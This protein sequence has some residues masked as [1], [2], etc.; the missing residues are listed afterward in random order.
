MN[1][2]YNCAKNCSLSW[3]H[4]YQ[5]PISRYL[6]YSNT[7]LLV[8]GVEGIGKNILSLHLAKSILCEHNNGCDECK[9]CYLFNQKNHPDLFIAQVKDK[10]DD[11]KKN[12]MSLSIGIDEIHNLIEALQQTNYRSKHKVV[13]IHTL[14][15]LTIPASN[16]LLKILEEPQQNIKFI[17]ISNNIEK[18]LPTIKSRCMVMHINGPSQIQGLEHIKQNN[19]LYNQEVANLLCSQ[20]L[21]YSYYNF[22]VHQKT[23]EFLSSYTSSSGDIVFIPSNQQDLRQFLHIFAAWLYD[24]NKFVYT[25]NCYY[26]NSVAESLKGIKINNPVQIYKCWNTVLEMSKNLQFNLNNKLL[27]NILMQEYQKIFS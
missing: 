24:L 20:P 13:I 19:N 22:T 16:A 21:K 8:H 25:K 18:I 7:P 11:L 4:V 3:L 15:Q 5:K 23:I 6:S 1:I 27:V 10:D 26:F 14:E 2:A 9:D 17:L 12:T